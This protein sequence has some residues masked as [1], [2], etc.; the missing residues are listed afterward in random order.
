M[1]KQMRWCLWTGIMQWW[2]FKVTNICKHWKKDDYFSHEIM[3]KWSWIVQRI[4][5]KIV[6]WAIGSQY[7]KVDPR[8]ST[9]I[10]FVYGTWKKYSKVYQGKSNTLTLVVLLQTKAPVVRRDI[11]LNQLV[12]IRQRVSMTF[13]KMLL[14][15][16]K[17]LD[18]HWPTHYVLHL[19]TSSQSSTCTSCCLCQF[20][21]LYH[22]VL[23]I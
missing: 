22:T 1:H 4:D 20:R 14:C 9:T 21:Q 15:M 19:H 6:K 7:N 8:V 3:T 16:F 2:L 11:P 18:E 12:G 13:P 5:P 10:V 17:L 23:R